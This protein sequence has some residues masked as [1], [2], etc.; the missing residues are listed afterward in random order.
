MTAA[1]KIGRNIA[2]ARRHAGWSQ[3][4]LAERVPTRKQ[5][6]S[7]LERGLNLP[8]LTTL[9]QVAGA[10]GVPLTDLLEGIE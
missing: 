5:E 6:I 2:L 3:A 1:Q 8:R 4:E 7:R 10:I 9:L